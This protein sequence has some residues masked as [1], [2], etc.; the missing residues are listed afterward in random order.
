[1]HTFI[2]ADIQNQVHLDRCS[3]ACR[4]V[5][6]NVFGIKTGFLV[7]LEVGAFRTLVAHNVITARDGALTVVNGSRLDFLYNQV[8]QGVVDAPVQR[9]RERRA[10]LGHPGRSGRS[11]SGDQHHRQQFRRRRERGAEPVDENG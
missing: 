2:G 9:Q 10:G 1:M 3:D 8:E 7:D 11:T 6:N 4:F 5:Y